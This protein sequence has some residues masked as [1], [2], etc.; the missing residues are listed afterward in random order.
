MKYA[1]LPC[2]EAHDATAGCTSLPDNIPLLPC[3]TGIEIILFQHVHDRRCRCRHVFRFP[4]RTFDVIVLTGN[5]TGCSR[6][7]AVL[8][9]ETNAIIVDGLHMFMNGDPVVFQGA[10]EG[11]H[12]LHVHE[13]NTENNLIFCTFPLLFY[14]YYS[15]NV[16]VL[17]FFLL[18]T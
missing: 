14:P 17:N 2:G 10:E 18:F 12:N 1:S 9:S 11:V 13:I 15:T 4:A 5:R 6:P 7:Q 8:A 16:L 3:G